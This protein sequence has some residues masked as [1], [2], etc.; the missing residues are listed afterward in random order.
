MAVGVYVNVTE[1]LADS[2]A[3]DGFRPAGI[4]RG[5]DPGWAL[6]A[7]ANLVTIFVGRHEIAKFVARLWA[8]ARGRAAT[9]THDSIV[10]I[11]HGDQRVA[12]TLEHEGF[13]ED[14]PPQA[15]VRGMTSMLEALAELDEDRPAAVPRSRP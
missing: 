7:G 14:G 8:A 15:V 13:G 6:A 3:G 5:I 10:I 9:G 11:E 12:I 1:Q 4:K 2:L